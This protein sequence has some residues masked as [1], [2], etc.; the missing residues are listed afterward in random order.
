MT[1]QRT[2][3]VWLEE[4]AG[5]SVHEAGQ[6]SGLPRTLLEHLVDCGALPVD[7]TASTTSL[8]SEGVVLARAASR[9]RQHFELDD[10][11][12]AVAVS[13]LR[14]VRVLEAELTRARA[15]ARED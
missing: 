12:L 4:R 6:W 5:Y 2:Q 3:V 10:D 1:I 13:L 15:M 9:L 14:R 11:G 8:S 7:D